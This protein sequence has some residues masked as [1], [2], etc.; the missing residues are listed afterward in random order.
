VRYYIATRL[1][2]HQQHNEVRDHLLSLGHRI[3]YDWTKHGPV[4]SEG[5]DRCRQVALF[6]RR[7]VEEADYVVVLLP[8]GRGTHVE[9]GI[10]LATGKRVVIWSADSR[11][12]EAVP[13][14]CAFYHDPSIVWVFGGDAGSLVKEIVSD[15]EAVG[16]LGGEAA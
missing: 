5:A 6:E 10:A 13:E 2:N 7:G 11:V 4:W 1:E 8:G 14:T 15:L 16:L 9:L 3:T 12:A